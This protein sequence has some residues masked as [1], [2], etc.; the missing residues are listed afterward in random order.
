MSVAGTVVVVAELE[1]SLIPKTDAV[2]IAGSVRF[3]VSKYVGGV[4]GKIVF[5][6]TVKPKLANVDPEMYGD[7][8]ALSVSAKL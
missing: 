2:T 7:E 3:I 1:A 4:L 8:L 5:A 6:S